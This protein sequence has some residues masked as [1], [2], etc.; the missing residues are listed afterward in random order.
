MKHFL[1]KK[2]ELNKINNKWGKVYTKLNIISIPAHLGKKGLFPIDG[3]QCS[4]TK[5]APKQVCHTR[6]DTDG[7]FKNI[8]PRR[9]RAALSEQN[10]RWNLCKSLSP[11]CLAEGSSPDSLS[12]KAKKL[13]GWWNELIWWIPF[14]SEFGPQRRRDHGW[15]CKQISK[16]ECFLCFRV[17]KGQT[18]SGPHAHSTWEDIT[19]MLG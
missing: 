8:S 15:Q 19:S 14:A 18:S 12:W 3:G 10:C 16:K 2:W 5:V 9:T 6:E 13:L 7:E 17:S 4:L 1:E 11:T